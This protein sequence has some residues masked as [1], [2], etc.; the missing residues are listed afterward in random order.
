[1]E[2]KLYVTPRMIK[3]IHQQL[4]SR[5]MEPSSF[6]ELLQHMKQEHL[7]S[8]I[9]LPRPRIDG[10]MSRQE[11]MEAYDN[12][13][14]EVNQLLKD[15]TTERENYGRIFF[16]EDTDLLCMQHIYNNAIQDQTISNTYTITYVYTG[17]CS[18]T[19][20]DQVLHVKDGDLFIATPGFSHRLYTSS[21][22]FALVIMVNSSSFNILFNDFLTA[23]SVLSDFFRQSIAERQSGNYCV[24]HGEVDN[25]ELRFYLQS[26]VCETLN[27][28]IYSNTNTVCL[29][30]LFLT[31]TYD[32]YKDRIAILK[33]NT[34]DS[35]RAD[36]RTIFNYIRSHYQDITL[37]E[38]AR[39]FH[40][41]KTYISRFIH[42]HYGKTFTEIVNS[43]KIE[44]A[45]EYL[46]K[47]NK[48]M[49][50]IASLAGFESYDHFSRTFKKYAGM[51]PAAY[52]NKNAK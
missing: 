5:G 27:P 9:P 47:T 23:D 20:D 43:L 40:Y 11:F 33:R 8:D 16:P 48:H 49:T 29:L 14:F 28:S 35:S 51:S 31:R 50:E 52:R 46:R 18:Y 34:A 13:P 26:L 24:V 38:V 44:H 37:T 22:T 17:Y 25:N 3:E 12:I 32:L 10:R 4:V 21:D 41:N 1:M 19:F 39:H 15:I 42:S 2:D 6:P 30:K 7:L 36:A 45:Q